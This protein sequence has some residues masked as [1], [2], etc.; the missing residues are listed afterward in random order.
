MNDTDP[1]ELGRVQDAT[2][3]EWTTIRILVRRGVPLQKAIDYALGR[4]G[5]DYSPVPRAP[6][7]PSAA[8]QAHPDL[9]DY[10]GKPWHLYCRVQVNAERER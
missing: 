5:V 7:G 6:R 9:C 2:S 8:Y 1:V 10:C 3:S 4:N